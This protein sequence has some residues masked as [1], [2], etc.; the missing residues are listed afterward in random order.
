MLKITL[1]NIDL[2][3]QA[4]RYES[5]IEII[6]FAL[7]QS[8]RPIVSTSFGTYS[9]TILHAATQVKKDIQVIWCDTGYNTEAT[10][11]HAQEL[12]SR[13]DLT[14]DIF[15]PGYTKGFLDVTLG[16]PETNDPNHVW[17]SQQVKLEPF[18]R[19]LKKYKPDIWLTNLRKGQNSYRDQLDV[20]S[21]TEEGIL[22]VCPFY[23][24]NNDQILQYLNGYRLPI[25]NDYFDPVKAD[26]TRECG[27]HLGN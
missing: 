8:E 17:F 24:W 3:N 9:A 27:I 21:F 2:F 23:H 26:S 13:L 1:K 14:V 5:P 7:D 4:L 20:L 25:L 19:A 10:Y 12:M 6:S 15:T 16:L 18:E 11:K 22:K